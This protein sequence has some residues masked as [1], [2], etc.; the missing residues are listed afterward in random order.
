MTTPGDTTTVGLKEVENA[1][2]GKT[3]RIAR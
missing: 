3:A 2:K 1:I